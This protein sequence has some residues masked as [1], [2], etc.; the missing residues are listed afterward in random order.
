MKETMDAGPEFALTRAGEFALEISVCDKRGHSGF[1]TTSVASLCAVLMAAF[2]DRTKLVVFRN[3]A[4]SFQP[5]EIGMIA[6]L[7][8]RVVYSAQVQLLLDTIRQAPFFSIFIADG[9]VEG[10]ALD[11]CIACDWRLATKICTF[12][13]ASN[14]AVANGLPD[15]VR[16]VELIGEFLALD[17]LLRQ[18]RLTGQEAIAIGLATP[19]DEDSFVAEV[20]EHVAGVEK[21]SIAGMRHAVRSVKVADGQLSRIVD[22]LSVAG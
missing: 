7:T 12:R 15:N 11:L 1:T 18:R 3:F 14:R 17:M 6:D 19:A 16:L 5:D 4:V 8:D 21:Q 9:A 10:F 2:E 22:S 13:F 20:L